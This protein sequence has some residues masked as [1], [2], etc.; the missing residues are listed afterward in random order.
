[1]ANLFI[2]G[3]DASLLLESF[4][5]LSWNSDWSFLGTS[6]WP[7]CQEALHFTRKTGGIL[8][9][10]LRKLQIAEGNAYLPEWDFNGIGNMFS[11]KAYQLKTNEAYTLIY[12]SNNQDY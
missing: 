8:H 1:M 12:L 9:V 5:A 4:E 6:L 10:V 2:S 7:L 11:G 3:S